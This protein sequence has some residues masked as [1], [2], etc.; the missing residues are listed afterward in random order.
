MK[1][2]QQAIMISHFATNLGKC[3]QKLLSI[4]WT[5]IESVQALQDK[6]HFSLDIVE[7]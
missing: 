7:I 1:A 3:E 2:S 6:V 4:F 5:K